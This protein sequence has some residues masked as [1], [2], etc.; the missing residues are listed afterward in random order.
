[1]GAAVFGR[2]D[3]RVGDA[4]RGFLH[5]LG[6]VRF[7]PNYLKRDRRWRPF[8]VVGNAS[9]DIELTP[10]SG[11][12]ESKD[13]VPADVHRAYRREELAK[14][15]SAFCNAMRS[16]LAAGLEFPPATAISTVACTKWPILLRPDC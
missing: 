13:P 15:D 4:W 10:M 7:R 2:N 14:M 12:R 5:H 16:A 8:Y 1:M 11:K 3:Q 9:R 6:A